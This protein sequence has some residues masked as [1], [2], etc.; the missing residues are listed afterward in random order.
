[1]EGVVEE[2]WINEVINIYK[3]LIEDV[4]ADEAEQ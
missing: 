4:V 1:L 2:S 3:Q